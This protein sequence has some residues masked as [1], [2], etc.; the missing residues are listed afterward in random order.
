[1]AKKRKKRTPKGK[2]KDR[3][4]PKKQIDNWLD[5]ATKQIMQQNFPG[6]VKTCRRILRYAPAKAKERGEALEHLATAYTMLKQFEEAYQALS[7]ALEINPHY[8]HLW[9]NRGLTGRYTMRLVQATRDFEKAVELETDPGQRKK[10]TKILAQTRRLAESERALRGPDFTLEQLEEQQDLFERGIHLMRRE[11]WT[12]AEQAFRQVT[13]M[14][15]CLPQP[16]GNLGLALLMQKKYDEAEAAFKRALEIDPD[17]DLAKQN[18]AM[19]P[20]TRQTGHTPALALREPFAKT[21]I[22]LTVQMVDED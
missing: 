12:E 17:Y 10:F 18:L 19:L 6:V 8:A 1:M 5:Q 7:Q 2:R 16:Q 20:L 13:E 14:A 21:N 22:G 15:D 9:Y 4:V 3:L 11:K